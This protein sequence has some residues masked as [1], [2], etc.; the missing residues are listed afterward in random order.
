MRNIALSRFVRYLTAYFFFFFFFLF[1]FFSQFLFRPTR[2][3]KIPNG[4]DNRGKTSAVSILDLEWTI[5]LKSPI[6]IFNLKCIFLLRN[7]SA[8]IK[9]ERGYEYTSNAGIRLSAF[10]AL[11]STKRRVVLAYSRFVAI[12]RRKKD[13]FHFLMKSA[14][15]VTKRTTPR[16]LHRVCTFVFLFVHLHAFVNVDYCSNFSNSNKYIIIIVDY[17]NKFN[18]VALYFDIRYDIV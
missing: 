1:P 18:A 12:V 16:K 17:C 10:E 8:G 6:E 5:N 14:C 3:T 2:C 4:N 13:F 9:W 15:E 7:F 11:I